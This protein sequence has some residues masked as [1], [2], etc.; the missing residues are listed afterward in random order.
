[1]TDNFP[2]MGSRLVEASEP[3][4]GERLDEAR[5]KALTEGAPIEVCRLVT[6]GVTLIGR[7]AS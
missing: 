5:I 2:L 4:E 7:A 1:M 6:D 3:A